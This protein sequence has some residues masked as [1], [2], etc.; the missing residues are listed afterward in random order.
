MLKFQRRQPRQLLFKRRQAKRLKF[1]GRRERKWWRLEFQG[2][3]ECDHSV[4]E[5]CVHTLYSFLYLFKMSHCLIKARL[6]ISSLMI[7]LSVVYNN[8]DGG[9]SI[10]GLTLIK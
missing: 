3:P 6:C 10:T 7:V 4:D 9:G 1:Q 2:R 5:Y 8:I